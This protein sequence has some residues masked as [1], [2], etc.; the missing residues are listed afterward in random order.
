MFGRLI[1]PRHCC[2]GSWS[3]GWLNHRPPWLNQKLPQH[4]APRTTRIARAPTGVGW[5]PRSRISPILP[6][7]GFAVSEHCANQS[8]PTASPLSQTLGTR[9]GGTSWVPRWETEARGGLSQ[10]NACIQQPLDFSFPP[11]M[12]PGIGEA[13][14]EKRGAGTVV[15]F[16][17]CCR[18]SRLTPRAR[19][20][21][22]TRRSHSCHVLHGWAC[23]YILFCQPLLSPKEGMKGPVCRQFIVP[24]ESPM[25]AEKA[26][27]FCSIWPVAM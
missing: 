18:C 5:S 14:G 11:G 21:R 22:V 27:A 4:R 6:A 3:H 9:H 13:R 12:D 8:T 17:G 20:Q 16:W 19:A 24:H 15:P 1:K 23:G 26:D 10:A 7:L 25:A 2:L